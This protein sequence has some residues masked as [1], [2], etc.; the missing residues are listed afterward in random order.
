MTAQLGDE[1]DGRDL[2]A[3]TFAQHV[4]V[5]DIDPVELAVEFTG[6]TR[7]LLVHIEAHTGMPGLELL[8]GIG[9]GAA[10]L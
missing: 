3:R 8:Q 9:R 1:E 10:A 4:L 7:P 6:L 5:S 2:G